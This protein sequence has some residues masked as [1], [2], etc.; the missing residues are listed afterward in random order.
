MLAQ[1]KSSVGQMA[2]IT[3]SASN[4]WE[5]HLGAKSTSAVTV[6]VHMSQE[7]AAKLAAIEASRLASLNP[8]RSDLPPVT[9]AMAVLNVLGL[10]AAN[11]RV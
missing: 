2:T 3:Q 4:S 8:E 1:A 6:E 11:G 7:T 5:I 10:Y 9:P